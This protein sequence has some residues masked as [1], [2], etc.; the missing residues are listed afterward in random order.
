MP[1]DKD[2]K[3][4][5]RARMKKTGESYTAARAVVVAR[6]EDPAARGAAPRSEWPSLA[7]VSDDAVKRSTGRTWAAWVDVLDRAGAHRMRHGDIA[8][9]LHDTYEVPGWWAQ[10]VTVGYER[11]RG[12]RAV[13]QRR[14]GAYEASKS[15]TFPVAVSALYRMFADTRRRKRWLPEGLT[16]VRTSSADTSMRVD[17]RDGTHVHFYFTRKGA[18]KSVVA[19]QHVKLA[20]KAAVD[21]AKAFWAERLGVL[22]D[23]LS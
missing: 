19:V 9:L 14:D 11:I 3:R 12:L 23:V 20:S 10:T 5:V 17:W 22:A 16:R 1:T 4:L 21:E 8:T 15:R 2:K 6:G 18:A 13:G 7:G